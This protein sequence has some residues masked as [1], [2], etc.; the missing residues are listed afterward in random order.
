MTR[1]LGTTPVGVPALALH[2]LRRL[3]EE[4]PEAVLELDLEELASR[5]GIGPARVQALALL[6]EALLAGRDQG[7][8][9]RAAAVPGTPSLPTNPVLAQAPSL[10]RPLLQRLGVKDDQGLA[11]L[12]LVRLR[13]EPAVGPAKWQVMRGLVRA[14]RERLGVEG[15]L[16]AALADGPDADRP[17][18]EIIALSE[19]LT[20]PLRRAGVH[21]LLDLA[22]V[23]D[24]GG[25]PGF[26]DELL[27]SLGAPTLLRLA[28]A[29]RTGGG[30]SREPAPGFQTFAGPPPTG[31]VELSAA[32]LD[33]LPLRPLQV[34][35][36]RAR[37]ASLQEIG[38]A[39]GRSREWCRRLILDWRLACSPVLRDAAA[40]LAARVWAALEMRVWTDTE[41][42]LHLGAP[43]REVLLL[44][45]VLAHLPM[46]YQERGVLALDRELVIGLRL[47]LLGELELAGEAGAA[48]QALP[49][50]AVQASPQ[51][52]EAVLGDAVER[53]P[54]GRF[55]RSTRPVL[56]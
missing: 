7:Q 46:P 25:L 51:A 22:R 19:T 50:G 44:P 48:L 36:A 52:R 12:D 5:P 45:F 49:V 29:V 3:G 56:G 14:A 10:V 53:L 1:T 39:Q 55:R 28:E 4:R 54:D 24:G 21:R 40:D 15:P 23:I 26:L 30:A 38:R 34:V 18:T 32:A 35:L 42:R 13:I 41:A 20:V 17:W 6:R 9:P 47:R 33:G 8:P 31:F 2:T 27:A 11:A 16:G 37:G 43:S